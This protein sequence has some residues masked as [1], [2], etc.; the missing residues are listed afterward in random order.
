MA[1]RQPRYSIEEFA[2]RG[3]LIYQAEIRPQVEADNHGKI[4]AVTDG[5]LFV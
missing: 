5:P 4:V 2:E 3:D 1:V